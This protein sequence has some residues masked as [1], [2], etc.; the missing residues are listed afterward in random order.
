MFAFAGGVAQAGPR[1]TS[2]SRAASWP[3]VPGFCL[4]FSTTCGAVSTSCVG[5]RVDTWTRGHVDSVTSNGSSP[6][7]AASDSSASLHTSTSTRSASTKPSL[8]STAP[9][10]DPVTGSSWTTGTSRLGFGWPTVT[11][12]RAELAAVSGWVDVVG[13]I[14]GVGGP[15]GVVGCCLAP[16]RVRLRTSG[17]F[18]DRRRRVGDG[19]WLRPRLV[20]NQFSLPAHRDSSAPRSSAR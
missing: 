9:T 14:R 10:S 19:L 20:P 5:G 7:A 4:R 2:G 11:E 12:F 13:A 8:P 18:D 3:T 15:A 1:S 16:R 6:Q 17:S